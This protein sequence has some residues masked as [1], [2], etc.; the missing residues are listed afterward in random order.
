MKPAPWRRD[1]TRLV[2]PRHPGGTAPP[3]GTG[4]RAS[5]R[6]NI[7]RQIPGHAGDARGKTGERAG[8]HPRV[9]EPGSALPDRSLNEDR[10]LRH[11][12]P[13]GRPGA[14]RA[15]SRPGRAG[16]ADR[17]RSGGLDAGAR[18]VQQA[19]GPTSGP[20]GG[21]ISFDASGKGRGFRATGAPSLP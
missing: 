1:R 13:P 2:G 6:K 5:A 17:C 16:K 11:R 20:G 14:R 3:R 9:Q 19:G 10:R 15:L 7:R 12:P 8:C 4:E 18:D 21:P